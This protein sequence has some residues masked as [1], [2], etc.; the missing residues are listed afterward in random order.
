MIYALTGDCQYRC[1]GSLG[2]G[3]TL[4]IV[5][6]IQYIDLHRLSWVGAESAVD[7]EIDGSGCR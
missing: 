4:I 5:T 7:K 6:I 2:V 3:L 1:N